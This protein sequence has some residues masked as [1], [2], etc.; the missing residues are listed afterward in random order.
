[1][2]CDDYGHKIAA[3]V[4]FLKS[5]F[6]EKE[7]EFEMVFKLSSKAHSLTLKVFFILVS[8]SWKARRVLF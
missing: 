4:N 5:Y 2:L 8:T 6:S 7:K 1:M 3:G